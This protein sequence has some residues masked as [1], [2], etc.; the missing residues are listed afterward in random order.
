MRCRPTAVRQPCQAGGRADRQRLAREYDPK[1]LKASECFPVADNDTAAYWYETILTQDPNNAEAKQVSRSCRS[2]AFAYESIPAEQRRPVG[3][4]AS[5]R[6]PRP[7]T[8][9]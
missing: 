3:V 7:M 8:N 1:Y 9:R 5:A 2:D 4:V 6:C